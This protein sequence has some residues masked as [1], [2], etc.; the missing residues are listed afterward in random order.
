MLRS[1][2]SECIWDLGVRH[3]ETDHCIFVINGFIPNVFSF[4]APS[5]ITQSSSFKLHQNQQQQH[6]LYHQGSEQQLAN[7]PDNV[8][9]LDEAQK[10]QNFGDR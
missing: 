10:S 8:Q 1:R 6:R 7:V 2:K 4:S 5:S 9:E 3:S